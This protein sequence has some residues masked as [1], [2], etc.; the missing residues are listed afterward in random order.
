MASGISPSSRL[1]TQSVGGWNH[2][3]KELWN[4]GCLV[5]YSCGSLALRSDIEV[6]NPYC[7]TKSLK[8]DKYVFQMEIE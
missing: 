6:D 2:R 3:D 5:Y 4:L 8:V 1:A 7:A